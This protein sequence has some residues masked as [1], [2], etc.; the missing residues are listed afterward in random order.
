MNRF[1]VGVIACLSTLAVALPAGATSQPTDLIFN[2]PPP[3]TDQGAPGGRSQG[4]ASRGD[5]KQYQQLTALVPRTQGR[6]W[7][8]TANEHPTFWFYL[9]SALT[10]QA[11]VEFAL[12]D[13]T[14]EEIY[15]TQFTATDTQ[16]GL[17]HLTIPNTAPVIAPNKPYL[18]TL[19]ISCNPARPSDSVFV[20]GTIQR[21]SLT[22]EQQRQITTATP[23]ERSRLYARLGLWHDALTSL[24]E[25]RQTNSTQSI[26]DW[27]ALLQQ[28]GLGAVSNQ[29]VSSCC[30]LK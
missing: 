19:T 28:G 30:T 14:D 24:G 13:A 12:Q 23:Q 11:T 20:Q 1:Q 16:P 2:A 9:P 8:L 17:I 21:A 10:A 6:V 3:P 27:S 25:L 15:R 22:P 18:W 5:C 7:A 29:P 26:A 4:G